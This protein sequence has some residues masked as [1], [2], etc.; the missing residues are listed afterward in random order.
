MIHDMI[1]RLAKAEFAEFIDSDSTE[2][3]CPSVLRSKFLDLL[4]SR[5]VSDFTD[6]IAVK[7][8][9]IPVIYLF[10][11]PSLSREDGSELV[12]ILNSDESK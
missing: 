4:E 6:S 10:L 7:S 11:F 5:G 9:G 3:F 12:S 8:R 2:V 1:D